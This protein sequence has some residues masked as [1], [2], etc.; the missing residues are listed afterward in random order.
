MKTNIILTI[1]LFVFLDTLWAQNNLPILKTNKSNLS[2]WIGNEYQKDG[3]TIS[4]QLNP[5]NLTI[6]ISKKTNVSF[7]SEKDSLCFVVI[8]GNTYEFIV[9][10]NDS[11]IAK[12]QIIAE[13]IIQKANYS[14]AYK[15]EHDNTIFVEIPEVYELV[16]ILF[17]LTSTG[18]ANNQIIEKSIPYYLTVLNHFE[19]YKNEKIVSIIDS[20]ISQRPIYHCE[21][22][23]DAYSFQ[24]NKQS[25]I[26]KSNI[27]NI[28]SRE[29]SNT[30][31]PYIP[32]LQDFAN[33]TKFRQFY[34]ENKSMYQEQ[35]RFYKD[36]IDVESMF[37]W[38]NVNFP[39]TECNSI[40]IVFSPLVSGW[41]NS[42]TLQNNNFTEVFAHVNY[43]YYFSNNFS[44]VANL[45]IQGNAI[46]TELNHNFLS[47]QYDRND[48]SSQINNAIHNLN[49]WIDTLKTARNY[50]NTRACFD[51]YMNWGLVSL[52]YLE[53][54]PK[55]ELEKLFENIEN[56]MTNQR[57]FTKFN[58]FNRFLIKIYQNRKPNETISD[59]YPTIINW[60]REN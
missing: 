3:W 29:N 4:P 9:L 18:K 52:W 8:P 43:P 25:K 19:K 11:I 44:P 24:F 32:L 17:A 14:T 34:N 56:F 59:L 53:K 60:F 36:S 16:N 48:Y 58:A 46:F 38:L 30:I 33:K 50:Y 31:E 20:L 26:I 7:V 57:G 6:Q 5:D 39:N 47:S 42:N 55:A 40:K 37:K 13:K 22:K 51:E 35:I 41:Q 23:L 2:Y 49:N 21:L 15:K 27:Y 10:Q 54:A 12:T 28:T 1:L 45:L